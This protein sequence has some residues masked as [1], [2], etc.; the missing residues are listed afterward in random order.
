MVLSLGD[1]EFKA[2]NFDQLQKSIDFGIKSQTRLNNYNILFSSYKGNEN[3][4]IT[5]KTLPL[6]G[7]KNTYLE[8]LEKMAKKRMAYCL[9]GAN[10]LF[11]GN[12]IILNINQTQSAFIDGSGFATCVF[13]LSLERVFDEGDL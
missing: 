1:F 6:K 13:D 12:F 10:G 7:D 5:G 8:P 2:L 3:I 9:C 4:K 11:Y